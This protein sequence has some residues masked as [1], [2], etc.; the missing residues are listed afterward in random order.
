MIKMKFRTFLAGFKKG[1]DHILE[2][3]ALAMEHL[4]Q[5]AIQ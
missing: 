1:H 4:Y 3:N 2:F 5:N